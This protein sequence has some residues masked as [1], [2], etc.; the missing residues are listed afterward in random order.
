VGDA[1]AAPETFE[2]RVN[3]VS[4]GRNGRKKRKVYNSKMQQ[5]RWI[6]DVEPEKSYVHLPDSTT[7]Q[8]AS[9]LRRQGMR[10]INE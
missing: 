6:L 5:Q 4:G 8:Q 7:Q 10:C 3:G 2:I 9:N 1:A